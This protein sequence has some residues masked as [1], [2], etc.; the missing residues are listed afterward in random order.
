MKATMVVTIMGTRRERVSQMRLPISAAV[1][2]DCYNVFFV[3]CHV[4]NRPG[5]TSLS[6]LFSPILVSGRAVGVV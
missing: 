4:E 5:Y 2:V 1:S 6:T 3:L